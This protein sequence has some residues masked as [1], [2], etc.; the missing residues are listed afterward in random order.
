MFS[1]ILTKFFCAFTFFFSI[2]PSKSWGNAAC[3]AVQ[4]E[5]V[6]HIKFFCKKQRNQVKMARKYYQDQEQSGET[7]FCQYKGLFKT[8]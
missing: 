6:M 4:T 7:N 8:L 3:S 5:Q 1:R 2:I